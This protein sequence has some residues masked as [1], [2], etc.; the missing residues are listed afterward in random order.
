MVRGLLWKERNKLHSLEVV[1]P[2]DSWVE[3]RLGLGLP[4]RPKLL[5]NG[6]TENGTKSL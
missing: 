1:L 6:V 2:T 3:W 4:Q 5:A